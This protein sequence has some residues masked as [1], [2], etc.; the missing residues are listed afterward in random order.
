M[1]IYMRQCILEADDEDK[2]LTTTLWL[3]DPKL[4]VGCLLRLSGDDTLWKLISM[5]NKRYVSDY[6]ND[7]SRDYLQTREASDI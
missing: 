5:G 4:K 6:I 1:S 7:R 2:K 3:D